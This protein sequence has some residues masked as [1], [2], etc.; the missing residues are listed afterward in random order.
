[1][2]K[3]SIE[4]ADKS[5][6]YYTWK[7]NKV[8]EG[9][10]NCYMMVQAKRYGKDPVGAPEWRENALKEYHRLQP[11][12][13]V[14]VNSMSDTYHESVPF[15][16]IERIHNLAAEKPEAIF[17]LLTKRPERALE[18]A[19]RL[20]WPANLWIGTS[21]ELSKYLHRI[22]TLLQI[23][24]T[25]HF[26]SAEPLLESLDLSSYLKSGLGWVILGA[27]S[28]NNRRPFDLQWARD[29]RDQCVAAGIPYLFKQ[30]GHF[31]SGQERVLDG[32]TWDETPFSEPPQPIAEAYQ[33][34]MF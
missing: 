26:L 11:G 18:L 22:D 24:A 2:G 16:W 27:E 34:R 29:T 25:G 21:V 4:W 6:N 33:L 10:K 32:R 12:D 28:G 19:P 23:P 1:M 31:K 20:Q 17:L 14:F 9:C 13:I 8:S 3:T 5:L 7:C 30:G 15:E